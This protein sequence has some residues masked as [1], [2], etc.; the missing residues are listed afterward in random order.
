MVTKTHDLLW[1]VV[2]PTPLKNMSASVGRMTFSI[3]GKIKNVSNH[4]SV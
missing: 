4:Q 1:S 3:Y 2:E